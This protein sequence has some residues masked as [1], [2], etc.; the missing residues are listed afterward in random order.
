MT[1]V[2]LSLGSNT[3][4]SFENLTEAVGRLNC[5]NST[6]VVKV[7]SV[8]KT[9]PWGKKDQPDFLNQSVLIGTDLTVEE[10][11]QNILRIEKEMGRERTEKW[12]PR[13]IDIDII[14]F[15]E[16]IVD[17]AGLTVPH[18]YANERL[19]VLEPSAEIAGEMVHPILKRSISELLASYRNLSDKFAL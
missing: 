16:Q 15:G 3:G 5:L 9:A 8:H 1:N 17:T 2:L 18:P 19:F 7:S 11:M 13:L 4:N 6:E 10:L 14:F 12:G